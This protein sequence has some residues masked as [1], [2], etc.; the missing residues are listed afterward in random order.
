MW[1]LRN[2]FRKILLRN[3]KPQQ[4]PIFRMC[5]WCI[6]VFNICF[7]FFSFQLRVLESMTCLLISLA[8][9]LNWKLIGSIFNLNWIYPKMNIRSKGEVGKQ[10]VD[11]SK[12]YPRNLFEL[13]KKL[14]IKGQVVPLR[15]TLDRNI[16]ED[17]EMADVKCI[18]HISVQKWKPWTKS[19]CSYLA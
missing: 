19:R 13:C 8:V 14:S 9:T 17:Q 15:D 2:L 16:I 7:F 12:R 1:D 11:R 3:M 4:S 6:D 5:G 10:I 18:F